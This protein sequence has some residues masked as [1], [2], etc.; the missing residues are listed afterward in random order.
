MAC[1]GCNHHMKIL[2]DD[3]IEKDACEL[4][5]ADMEVYIQGV[6]PCPVRDDG[7]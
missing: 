5:D 2:D 4:G 1:Q 3:C 6:E 7:K